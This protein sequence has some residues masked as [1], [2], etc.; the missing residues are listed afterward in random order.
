MQNEIDYN[1]F[2][3]Q[4]FDNTKICKYCNCEF[5]HSYNDHYIILYEI[6]DKEKLKYILDNNDFNEEVNNIAGNYYDSLDDNGCNRIIY[7]Q[8]CDK[9]RYYADSSCLTYLKKEIRD[10][11]IP[12]NIKKIRMINCH[13]VILNYLC[14]NNVDCNILKNFIENKELIL[15]SFGEELFLN[16]LNGSFKDIYLDNKQANNYLKLFEQEIIKI[17]KQFYIHDKRYLDAD[18]NYK[19]KNLSRIILDI[20]NQILQV[21]I[22]YFVSENVNKLTLEYDG[23]KIYSDKNSKHFSI[24]ELELNI[25]KQL[26][27][28]IKLAFKNIEDKFPEFGIRVLTDNIKNKNVIENEIKIVHHDHSLEKRILLVSY[29]G[30]VI[31]KLKIIKVFLC[32]FFNG[33]KHDNSIILKSI[34]DILKNDVTLNCIDNSCE[35]FKMIDFKFK[36]LKYGTKLLDMCNFIKG[37]L[38]ELSKN[39]NDKDEIITKQHFPDNFELLKYKVC[40]PY[41]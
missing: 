1:T 25:C 20:E 6:V 15:S 22:N 13:P 26:G 19:G 32:I 9:N 17:Q 36:K 31:C 3:Q 4:E 18:Y 7:K 28:N 30:S 38:S 24:N 14:K 21:M 40:F 23:L 34:C 33:M 12:K 10:S 29:A 37:S 8:T 16:I 11:M 5:N 41:E 39:L 2:N 27:I 35:S